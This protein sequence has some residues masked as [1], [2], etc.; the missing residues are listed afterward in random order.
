MSPKFETYELEG[1][2]LYVYRWIMC[3]GLVFTF[4]QGKLWFIQRINGLSGV[5]RKIYD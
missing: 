5:I 4:I 2:Q 1:I 3:K